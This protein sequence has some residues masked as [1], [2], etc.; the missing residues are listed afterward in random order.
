MKEIIS[1]VLFVASL[2]GG[3]VVLENIHDSLRKM[4]LE[5]A[6]RGMPSLSEMSRSLSGEGRK[7][8]P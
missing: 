3:T 4:A 2:Y 1:A 7:R 5:K 8:S 6:A